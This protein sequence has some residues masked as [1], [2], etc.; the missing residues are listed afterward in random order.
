MPQ[1]IRLPIMS[2]PSPVRFRKRR[3]R[4]R[5]TSADA[6][7]L[8]T[9][10]HSLSCCCRKKAGI[11]RNM[12]KQRPRADFKNPVLMISSHGTRWVEQTDLPKV[13][14]LQ[15]ET[16]VSRLHK[17]P[18]LSLCGNYILKDRLV[19]TVFIS[20]DTATETA[21]VMNH[22]HI[23]VDEAAKVKKVNHERA[24][25]INILKRRTGAM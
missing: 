7:G 5:K 2:L 4:N 13:D 17:G 3:P 10:I 22:I 19:L 12:S 1:P 16:E 9:T 6:L 23:S 11:R 20:A 15:K 8:P 14:R 18:A 21:R 25:P 24:V